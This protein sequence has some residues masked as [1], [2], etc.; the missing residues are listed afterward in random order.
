MFSRRLLITSATV[1]ALVSSACGTPE[2]APVK[3][4]PG[5]TADTIALGVLTDMSGP[6]KP[7]AIARIR[8]YELM[9]DELNERGGI[10]GRKIELKVKDHAY[11][12]DKALDGYFELEPKVLGFLDLAGAPMMAAI[13][14]DL[15]QTRALTAPASWSASLLGNPNMM[16][17]GATYDIDAI[18]AVDYL[19]RK[20]I[21]NTGDTFGHVYIEGNYGG[22]A[23]EGSTFAAGQWGMKLEAKPVNETTAD[24]TTQIA[25]LKASGAKAVLLSTT[26]QQTA[27]AILTAEKMGWDVPFVVSAVGYDPA[28][29]DSPAAAA[30]TKHALI[31][32]S[33]A[34]Y[35]S[36]VPGAK[37]VVDL[38]K[39]KHPDEKPTGS[40]NHGYAV[41]I[42]FAAVLEKACDER[43]MT[44]DGV[45]KAFRDTNA[46]NTQGITA[47]LHF[48]LAGRPSSTQ[49]FIS[50][51]DPSAPG[52]LVL[53]ENLFE[54]PL[55]QVRGTRVDK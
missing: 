55:I 40:V 37:H 15:M 29:L 16:V 4:G 34:P 10:C 28:I 48:S 5:V 46:V 32:S 14:P 26:P 49:S 1:V 20:N 44:R 25:G 2:A 7:G 36:D 31:A 24:L 50:K 43:D 13:E 35:G 6:F 45:L 47:A 27:V 23:L 38:M 19:K 9:V 3:T 18:N 33:T 41:A 17:V 53:V 42:A 52:T 54:S 21:V 12:V 8:G 30:V 11:N 51:I 22:N 39:Q